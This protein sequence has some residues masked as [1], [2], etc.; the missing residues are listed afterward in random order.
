[1]DKAS[2]PIKSILFI[3]LFLFIYKS[4][5]HLHRIMNMLIFLE[6]IIFGKNLKDNTFVSNAEHKK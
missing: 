4:C 1:M 5:P 3:I 2:N 6:K